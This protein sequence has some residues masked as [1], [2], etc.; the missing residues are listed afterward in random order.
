[1]IWGRPGGKIENGF[2]FSAECLLR[3]IFFPEKASLDLLFFLGKAFLDLFFPGEGPPKFFFSISSGPAPRSLMVVPLVWIIYYYCWIPTFLSRSHQ[4]VRWVLCTSSIALL[5]SL[6]I[7]LSRF[8]YKSDIIEEPNSSSKHGIKVKF[9]SL[10]T[11]NLAFWCIW[12]NQKV[13]FFSSL[14]WLSQIP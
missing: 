12:T 9:F 6:E 2:I 14:V 13:F 7:P 3:I 4:L 11:R 1:M 8:R 10:I 5:G